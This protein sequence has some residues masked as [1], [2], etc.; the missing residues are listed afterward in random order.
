MKENALIKG[1]VRIIGAEID[2]DK[3]E[4]I[5]KSAHLCLRELMEE[6]I[7]DSPALRKHTFSRI[8]P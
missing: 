3:A 6:N 2:K 1:T 4:R 5:S 8:Y 7:N